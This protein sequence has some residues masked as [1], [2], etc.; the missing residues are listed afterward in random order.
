MSSSYPDFLGSDLITD[1]HRNTDPL[2]NHPDDCSVS[3]E[4]D[5]AIQLEDETMESHSS[6]DRKRPEKVCSDR[7]KDSCTP[8]WL[9][10]NW[11]GSA[12]AALGEKTFE[13]PSYC[14]GMPVS[15]YRENKPEEKADEDINQSGCCSDD[16][17]TGPFLCPWHEDNVVNVK[18]NNETSKQVGSSKESNEK[19]A[20]IK[21]SCAS[22]LEDEDKKLKIPFYK[23]KNVL[24]ISRK[25]DSSKTDPFPFRNHK[26][27]N[28]CDVTYTGHNALL[29]PGAPRLSLGTPYKPKFDNNSL[30]YSTC[31]FLKDQAAVNPSEILPN[32]KPYTSDA[33]LCI[34][35]PHKSMSRLP[36]FPNQTPFQENAFLLQRKGHWSCE[37]TLHEGETKTSRSWPFK[38]AQLENSS[39]PFIESQT[40]NNSHEFFFS[41]GNISK[42]K[43]PKSMMD[44]TSGI[45]MQDSPT[46]T[47]KF[48]D[49][50]SPN[51]PSGPESSDHEATHVDHHDP[52]PQRYRV[53]ESLTSNVCQTKEGVTV[54]LLNSALWK[55]FST[56]GT[57]MI[58]NR[59]GRLVMSYC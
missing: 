22:S 49:Q 5:E 21:M 51:S 43:I 44:T 46:T 6:I 38:G 33:S 27:R 1:V 48:T 2:S 19:E 53:D 34:D 8:I 56:V 50:S 31:K 58:I 20:T 32:F 55:A 26:V 36:F 13:V 25:I 12:A 59:S 29:Y 14:S 41:S 35:D 3:D 17:K 28:I 15:F 52:S 39:L 40:F 23:K 4:R 45:S 30:K 42:C 57:E 10:N 7:A 18:Y 24:E 9:L 37:G 54:T 47:G 11:G 16:K